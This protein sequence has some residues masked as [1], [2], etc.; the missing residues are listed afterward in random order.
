[1]TTFRQAKAL[2]R[3]QIP[4]DCALVEDEITIMEWGWI[5]PW[6]SRRFVAT[7][8]FFDSL[9][10]NGDY[11]VDRWLGSVT[12]APSFL[13]S[14]TAVAHYE[15]WLFC[16]LGV[17]LEQLRSRLE[18]TPRNA[19]DRRFRERPFPPGSGSDPDWNRSP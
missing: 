15:R 4:K 3:G 16:S 17:S 18:A 5:I 6:N 1:V 11:F 19:P 8:D 9:L 10:G 12:I 2:V 7:R 14:R 13:K